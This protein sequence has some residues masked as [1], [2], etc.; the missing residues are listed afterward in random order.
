MQNDSKFRCIG[1]GCC[2]SVWAREEASTLVVKCEDGGNHGR[3]VT[4]DQLMHRRVLAGDADVNGRLSIRIP[5]SYAVIEA[6]DEWWT[7]NGQLFPT[8]RT[9][10]KA[11]MQE[12][13]PA[14]P[15]EIRELLIKRYCPEAIQDTT[16]ASRE[17]ED[18]LIRV[19]AGKRRRLGGRPPV[20]FNL[21][22][23]GLHI[24]QM[25]DLGLNDGHRSNTGIR[26]GTLLLERTRRRERCR[27][28][29]CTT[30]PST[31]PIITHLQDCRDR[32][33]ACDLD[34]RLR[35]RP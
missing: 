25:H 30:D 29:P 35:L 17:N 23:Y 34:A 21:R 27:I 28:R 26:F 22:N 19:Y 9:A 20:F 1:G 3:S 6:D 24:D 7:T 11:Y 2:G 32:A 15:L 4:N 10:C 33:G 16:R 14:V 18:C 31:T 5:K 12:R 8:N 13:I